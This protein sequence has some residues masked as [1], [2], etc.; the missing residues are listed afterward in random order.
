MFKN[1]SIKGK[2]ILIILTVTTFAL[3]LGFI[4]V[5]ITFRSGLYED[6]SH[7]MLNTAKIVADYSITPVRFDDKER[8]IDI[9][10][11][12]NNEPQI[13]CVHIEKNNGEILAFY[14]NECEIPNIAI[15]NGGEAL[16]YNGYLHII[17]PIVYKNNTL[18]RIYLKASTE[19]INN[20]SSRIIVNL[21]AIAL[22]IVILAYL[23]AS[24]LQKLISSPIMKLTQATKQITNES[25]YS[26]RVTKKNNDEIGTL[27]DGF[28]VMLK[29]IEYQQAEEKK[30]K[31]ALQLSEE[32]YR[33]IYQNSIIGIFQCNI[34]NAELIEANDK[35]WEMLNIR[36]T[37][38]SLVNKVI[39]VKDAL[40]IRRSVKDNGFIE[41]YE[42][43]LDS[44]GVRTWVSISGKYLSVGDEEIFEGVIK[45]ITEEKESFLELK[46]VNY[47][48]DNFVYHTSHDLRSPLLSILGLIS[49]SKNEKSL[50]AVLYYFELI[51]K[52]VKRLD[53]LVI[54]LLTLSR[55]SRVD[56][57]QQLIDIQETINET[58]EILNLNKPEK[59]EIYTDIKQHSKFYSDQTR[60][61]I[62]LNNL[63]SNAYKYQNPSEDKPFVRIE[64]EITEKEFNLSIQDNGLGI[65]QE[66]QAKVFEMFYRA[67][68]QAHGSGL[69]LYIVKNVIEKLDGSIRFTSAI[70]KG[71]TFHVKL[72]NH[73]EEAI[74]A[75][76]ESK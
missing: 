58:I 73:V 24:R 5:F 23:F 62:I 36:P 21:L 22:L 34:E 66:S 54:N 20:K 17:Q 43:T 56:E 2:L 51:E 70:R 67:T 45:D 18:G 4:A 63:I 38:D 16:F 55:N 39:S 13:E 28:N 74:L 30:S 53:A 50:D 7:S 46:R 41:N 11:K 1:L 37:K 14:N 25:N 10:E 52:S 31:K 15:P 3:I 19:E 27:Y 9:L 49:I 40:R 72:P 69:G 8:A 71:T 47:E 68:D 65:S 29:Q 59:L 64:V 32:K 44:N 35:T 76:E 75:E 42:I 33:N 12:L 26:L 48:L 6:L 61:N 57:K 60:L